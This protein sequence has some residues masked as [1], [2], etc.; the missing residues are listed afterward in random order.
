MIINTASNQDIGPI[1]QRS[2]HSHASSSAQWDH[3][4]RHRLHAH[5]RHSSDQHPLW[6]LTTSSQLGFWTLGPGVSTGRLS[7]QASRQ[8]ST[9]FA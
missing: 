7:V 9:S 2:G 4:P 8:F 3:Q 6:A 5:E 1:V